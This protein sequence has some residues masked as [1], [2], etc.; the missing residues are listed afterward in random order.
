MRALRKSCQQEKFQGRK[1]FVLAKNEEGVET[2][3]KKRV[4]FVGFAVLLED[5]TENS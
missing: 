2:R 3:G 4:V 5:S 1:P